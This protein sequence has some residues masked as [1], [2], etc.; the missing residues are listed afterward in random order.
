MKKLQRVNDVMAYI[1]DNSTR[2]RV[3]DYLLLLCAVTK[4]QNN[5]NGPD[6]RKCGKKRTVCRTC[7]GAIFG[8]LA[9]FFGSYLA[10]AHLC[11]GQ[12]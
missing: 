5:F 7:F 10:A 11:S 1:T 2:M 12:L 8:T 4:L 6:A 9:T 3:C